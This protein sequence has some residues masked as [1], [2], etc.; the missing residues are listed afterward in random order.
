MRILLLC[1]SVILASGEVSAQQ[2]ADRI[3]GVYL[4]DEKDAK[5]EIYK[6]NNV[7]FGK[8]V[9]LKSPK[10][11]DGKLLLDKNNPNKSLRTRPILGMTF[12]TDFK[13][14]EGEWVD[15]KI[16]GPKE[17]LT[18]SGK[19][20]FLTTGELELKAWYMFISTTRIWKRIQ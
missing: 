8:I 9:W 17:G 13:F 11:V 14:K 4:T 7:Y 15:G 3:L 19:F 2:A 20:R 5:V 10:S 12:I 1:I 16:Y 6:K 18:V